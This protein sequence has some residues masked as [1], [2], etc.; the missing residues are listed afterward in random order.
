MKDW[1]LN[2]SKF[3]RVRIEHTLLENLRK[4]KQLKASSP[5]S[6][7]VLIG[8]HLIQGGRLIIDNYTQPQTQDIKDRC[9]YYRS[10]RHN[11]IIQKTWVE[12]NKIS[13][14][15]GLWHTHPEDFP[16]YSPID[17]RDW[18][19]ALN[20]SV[21]DGKNLFFIIIGRTHMRC[22]M[23]TKKIFRSS[24]QAVGEYKII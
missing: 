12:S 23:G 7:G 22:W 19:T 18:I 21:F 3:G 5:E 24:I 6:G 17:K 10:G 4:F 20:R 8:K 9:S 2:I 15:V 14:Y 13:T 16:S 1:I 11:Q